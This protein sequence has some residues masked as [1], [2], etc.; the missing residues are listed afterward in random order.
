MAH[1]VITLWANQNTLIIINLIS[2]RV[3]VEWSFWRLLFLFL[4]GPMCLLFSFISSLLW[5]V[6]HANGGLWVLISVHWVCTIW[7]CLLSEV[8]WHI[9]NDSAID[10]NNYQYSHFGTC[11]ICILSHRLTLKQVY[12]KGRGCMILSKKLFQSESRGGIRLKCLMCCVLHQSG[13]VKMMLNFMVI[14]QVIL[15][16][17]VNLG[18]Q[19]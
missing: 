15:R 10:L 2:L 16:S 12:L 11:Y 3:T 5:L 19:T 1:F 6:S 9:F 4:C 14:S 18:W 7:I 17:L 13:F 8:M